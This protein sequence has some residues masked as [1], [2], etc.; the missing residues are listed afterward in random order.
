VGTV[1]SLPFGFPRFPQRVIST[2]IDNAAH[3]ES[4]LFTRFYPPILL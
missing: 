3:L 2:A 1:E 4:A